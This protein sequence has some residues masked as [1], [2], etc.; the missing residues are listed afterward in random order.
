[1][2]TINF[3]Y[4]FLAGWYLLFIV[5]G[6]YCLYRSMLN[7]LG[8]FGAIYVVVFVLLAIPVVDY[9]PISVRTFVLLLLIGTLLPAS[10][11][12]VIS[13]FRKSFRKVASA[14]RIKW[15]L[16]SFHVVL[17]ISNVLSSLGILLQFYAFVRFFGSIGNYFNN[18]GEVYIMRLEGETLIPSWIAY[19]GNIGYAA[20]FMA[21]QI[22]AVKGDLI[23]QRM[24][25]W[26]ILNIIMLSVITMGRAAILWG[27]LFFLI[28][29]STMLAFYHKRIKAAMRGKNRIAIILL[30]CGILILIIYLRQVR[31]SG[32]NFW[33]TVAPI[34]SYVNIPVGPH[35]LF[36]NVLVS[37]YVYFTG[38]VPT[39]GYVMDHP[40]NTNWFLRLVAPFARILGQDVVRYSEFLAI[41]FNFNARSAIGELYLAF[42]FWGT[43]FIFVFVGAISAFFYEKLKSGIIHFNQLILLSWLWGWLVWSVFFSLTRQGFFWVSAFWLVG[44]NIIASLIKMQPTRQPTACV[45]Q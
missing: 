2:G 41:P 6:S 7:P 35:N 9:R 36:G 31:G 38:S 18:L 32:D 37:T 29:Y 13:A 14:Q 39:L 5:G 33:S 21:G 27:G 34:K 43:L 1:M 22:L 45:F 20:V 30:S 4:L 3:T 40:D 11:F 15:D 24:V 28:G 42:G 23:K 17:L 8:M 12:V 25:F 16:S 26:S 10:Y 19:V 44:C